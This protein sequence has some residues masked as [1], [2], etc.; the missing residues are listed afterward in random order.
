VRDEINL[1]G[2]NIYDSSTVT[3]EVFTLRALVRS[4]NSGGPLV[5]TR[6]RV[7]GVIF[8]AAVDESETGFA[9]TANEVK[10]EVAG[11]PKESRAVGTGTCAA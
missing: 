10:Q 9:L 4:G 7:I 5:D 1:T 2:P 3:R 6:G 11:A 8:G